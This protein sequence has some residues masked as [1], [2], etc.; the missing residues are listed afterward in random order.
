MPA[1]DRILIARIGAPNGL[2]GEVRLLPF[3]DEPEA[4]ADYGPLFTAEGRSLTLASLRFQGDKLIARFAGV[5]DRTGAEKLTGTDLFI[6]RTALPETEED[7]FYLADLIGLDA[8]LADG[9][10]FGKI[11]AVPN[12]GAGDLLDIAPL[13]GGQ[14]VLIPFTRV[15]VPEID[16]ASR[17]VVVDP[18]LGLLGPHPD[19]EADADEDPDAPETDPAR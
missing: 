15:C 8:V 14:T 5:V 9:A 11:V 3:G 19:D 13:T 16:I 10:P 7:E 4:L 2:K 1:S 12:F 17:R 18:P 6:D